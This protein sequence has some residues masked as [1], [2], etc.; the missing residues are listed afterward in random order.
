LALEGPDIIAI[1]IETYPTALAGL[2]KQIQF[3]KIIN[4]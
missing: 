1:K 3:L 2:N 4:N